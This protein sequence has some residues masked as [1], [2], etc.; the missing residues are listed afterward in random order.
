[1]EVVE[2][3]V[4]AIPQ[5]QLVM[6]VPHQA[7]AIM[8]AHVKTAGV[9]AI[10]TI[11]RRQPAVVVPAQTAL[12]ATAV[13]QAVVITTLAH[14]K[15]AGVAATPHRHLIIAAVVVVPARQATQRH[16]TSRSR[17]VVMKHR[18]IIVVAAA[19]ASQVIRLQ[20]KAAPST[21]VGEAGEAVPVVVHHRAVALPAVAVHA[22]HVST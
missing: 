1:M 14:A 2:L 19:A 21:I 10:I 18:R 9:A 13:G 12:R 4:V 8:P 15:T 11:I 17:G 7:M 16:R 22:V 20:L 6:L 5:P 3:Q